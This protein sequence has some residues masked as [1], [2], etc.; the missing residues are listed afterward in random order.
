MDEKNL[1]TK[2]NKSTYRKAIYLYT[3]HSTFGIS[4]S[5]AGSIKSSLY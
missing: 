1:P 2:R 3:F 5:V 4:F